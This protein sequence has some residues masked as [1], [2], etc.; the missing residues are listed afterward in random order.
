MSSRVWDPDDERPALP[1]PWRQVRSS[2]PSLSSAAQEELRDQ[3]SRLEQL[4]E[5]RVHEARAAGLREGE[6][7][8]RGLASVQV[9]PLIAQ[10]SRTISDLSQLRAQLRREAESDMIK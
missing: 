1:V 2:G 10:L 3:T 4:C 6:A 5:Q 8:G 9:Q 7:A